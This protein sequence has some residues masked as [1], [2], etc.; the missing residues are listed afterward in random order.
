ME[1]KNY[2]CIILCEGVLFI[3]LMIIFS[4]LFQY[5]LFHAKQTNKTKKNFFPIQS[6]IDNNKNYIIIIIVFISFDFI[7]IKQIDFIFIKKK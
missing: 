4:S 1:N 2:N 3:L 5:I 7:I 6:Q